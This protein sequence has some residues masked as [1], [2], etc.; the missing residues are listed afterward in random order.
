VGLVPGSLSAAFGYR[1]E[2][3]GQAGRAG[4]LGAAGALGGLTGGVLLIEVAPGAFRQ[5][6]PALIL[7]ACALVLV[8]PWLARRLRR[9]HARP[10]PGPLLLWLVFVTSIYGGYFGAAQSVLFLALF[11][12]LLP[13]DLQRL[14]GL[15][16]L[17]AAVV[18][19][20]A[21][22]FFAFTT[23]VA[24]SAAALL[25]VGAAAGGQ[26]GAMLG[27]RLPERLL[28]LVIVVVGLVAAVKLLA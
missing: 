27:R 2:L 23:S 4:W 9:G 22:V 3:A 28:R 17:T 5:V 6:A 15:K 16:N 8:Q 25:A 26:L 14:N 1:R 10:R 19:A 11:A 21:A 18:N 24:W 13:D 7:V 20:V 12:A